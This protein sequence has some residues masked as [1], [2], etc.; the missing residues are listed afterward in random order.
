MIYVKTISLL[1]LVLLL[2]HLFFLLHFGLDI[3][4]CHHLS[5]LISAWHL[6]LLLLMHVDGCTVFLPVQATSFHRLSSLETFLLDE[7]LHKQIDKN[8]EY[9]SDLLG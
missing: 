1:L 2:R 9:H 6:L 5:L 7:F 4:V 8:W 3:N